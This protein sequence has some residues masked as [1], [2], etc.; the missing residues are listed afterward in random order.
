MIE[1]GVNTYSEITP[2]RIHKMT[3]HFSIKK[4]F[5]EEYRGIAVVIITPK[6]YLA[7]YS[8]GENKELNHDRFIDI[9]WDY[10]YKNSKRNPTIVIE[11]THIQSLDQ[12]IIQLPEKKFT[13]ISNKMNR[14]KMYFEKII[15]YYQPKEI[16]SESSDDFIFVKKYENL[17]CKKEE[18]VGIDIDRANRKMRAICE[19]IHRKRSENVRKELENGINIHNR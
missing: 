10:I 13:P 19:E 14:L 9:F 5:S 15:R 6:Q 2:E 18:I 11:L 7:I 16:Q 12:C 1:Y 4:F 17:N 8:N 3:I